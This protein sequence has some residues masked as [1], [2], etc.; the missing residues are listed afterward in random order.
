MDQGQ[1][2]FRTSNGTKRSRQRDFQRHPE[3]TSWSV[4][5][6]NRLLDAQIREGVPPGLFDGVNR[7]LLE[8]LR[9]IEAT[10]L[11]RGLKSEK[12]RE[13]RTL[14]IKAAHSV[15]VQ[16]EILSELRLLALT[17]DLTGFYNR[18]GFLILAMQQLKV[19]RRNSQPM[20]LFFIDVD[21]LKKTNDQYGHDEG[22]ALL[23]RSSAALNNT[24]R[25]SD[26]IARLGGDEFAILAAEGEDRSCDAIVRRLDTAIKDVNAQ[27]GITELSMSVG[28]A[29]FN[30]ENPVSLA[31]LLTEADCDMYRHKRGRTSFST[32]TEEFAG[33]DQ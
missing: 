5:S 25:E 12:L 18:R 23:L 19:S 16:S 22:D 3:K 15:A 2:A 6:S 33:A 8:L 20:L 21:H 26:I 4:A 13:I 17:D 27:G 30:P 1:T 9:K 14:L 11:R 24:F 7:G 32:E 28:V 29:R 10:S 31:E